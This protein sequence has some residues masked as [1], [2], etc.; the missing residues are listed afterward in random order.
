M[1]NVSTHIICQNVVKDV[2]TEKEGRNQERLTIDGK[3]IT[4]ALSI[5]G[6]ND[7]SEIN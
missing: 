1:V 7:V 4:S 5:W 3:M 6:C 2:S